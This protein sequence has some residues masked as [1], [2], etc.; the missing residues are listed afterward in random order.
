MLC[1]AE[2]CLLGNEILQKYNEFKIRVVDKA[3]PQRNSQRLATNNSLPIKK[4]N[5]EILRAL[6][7]RAYIACAA[8]AAC[9]TCTTDRGKPPWHLILSWTGCRAENLTPARPQVPVVEATSLPDTASTPKIL[10]CHNNYLI[11]DHLDRPTLPSDPSHQKLGQ[12]MHNLVDSDHARIHNFHTHLQ[13][14][15]NHLHNYHS[16]HRNR[17]I[18]TGS[19]NSTPSHSARGCPCLC[20][21]ARRVLLRWMVCH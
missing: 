3:I 2:L 6:I 16:F 13:I 12:T 15:Y 11:Y 9:E 1:S 5:Q 10:R 7:R 19:H 18:Q 20:S 8:A 17:H 21:I 4:I 14:C